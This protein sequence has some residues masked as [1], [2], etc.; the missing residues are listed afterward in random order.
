MPVNPFLNALGR[1]SAR[2]KLDEGEK[3][4]KKITLYYLGEKMLY[5]IIL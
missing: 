4:F 5:N 2:K 3:R 1:M